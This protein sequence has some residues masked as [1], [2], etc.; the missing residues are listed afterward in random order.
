MRID[1]LDRQSSYISRDMGV[2]N[3]FI[4]TG[5]L[6]PA[7]LRIQTDYKGKK[8]ST[9]ILALGTKLFSN[10]H[11]K[12]SK[13]SALYLNYDKATGNV[14]IDRKTSDHLLYYTID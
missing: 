10:I 9:T 3:G 12:D 1:R 13:S 2:K 7:I 4:P 14:V 6:C 11:V 5:I 8:H